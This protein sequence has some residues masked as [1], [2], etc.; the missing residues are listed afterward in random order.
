MLGT[1]EIMA[2]KIYMVSAIMELI[3][4]KESP[5]HIYLQIIVGILKKKYMVLSEHVTKD[6]A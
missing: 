4:I 5:K 2:S 1:R 6:L 3:S